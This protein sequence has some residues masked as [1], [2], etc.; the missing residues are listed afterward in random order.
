[1]AQRQLLRAVIMTRSAL[2][3][4]TTRVLSQTVKPVYSSQLRLPLIAPIHTTAVRWSENIFQVQDMADFNK[5]V[6]AGT[7]LIIVDFHA[8]WCGP[9]K[10]LGPRLETVI[11]GMA[12]KVMLAKVDVDNNSEIAI[13]YGVQAVPTVLA[14]KDGKVIDKFIGMKEEADVKVI[15]HQKPAS[16]IDL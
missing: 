12:G 5:R 9:C 1:M 8:S 2:T 3:S 11:A 16:V 7:G 13:D 15:H 10:M 6:I 4:M 14:L